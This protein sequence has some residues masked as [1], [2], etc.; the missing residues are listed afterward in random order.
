MSASFTYYSLISF[1][2]I[3][4]IIHIYAKHF[5][6]TSS[7]RIKRSEI[8]NHVCII[9]HYSHK[10]DIYTHKIFNKRRKKGIKNKF[11]GKRVLLLSSLLLYVIRTKKN[12]LKWLLLRLSSISFLFFTMSG[13]DVGWFTCKLD[14]NCSRIKTHRPSPE[15]LF[16]CCHCCTVNE[17]I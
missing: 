1:Q 7:R 16:R 10:E 4:L 6:M 3:W 17:L 9:Q 5:S 14:F 11:C 2:F 13:F 15:N 12:S 8:R